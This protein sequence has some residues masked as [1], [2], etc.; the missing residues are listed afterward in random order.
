MSHGRAARGLFSIF[1]SRRF[2]FFCSNV[3]RVVAELRRDDHLAE[4]LRDRLRAA[5]VQ[6]LVYGDDAA[7]GRL[8]VR[9]ERLVPRLAQALRPAR[10]R[11]GSYA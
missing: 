9:R 1:S 10:P 7:K 4:N 8:F 11:T 2:F 5:A 6:R 3:E